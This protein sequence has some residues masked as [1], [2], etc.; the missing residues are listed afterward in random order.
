VKKAYICGMKRSVI[1]KSVER[2]RG[3]VRQALSPTFLSIVLCAAVLWYIAKLG[4][5][6]TTELDM[7][8]RIDGQKY[9]LSVV[10]YGRGSAILAQQLSLKSRLNL[11]LDELSPRPSRETLGALTI[12]PAS[13]TKAINT[14]LTDEDIKIMEVT[15]APEFIPPGAD[16]EEHSEKEKGEKQSKKDKDSSDEGETPR[17]KRKRERLERRQAKEAAR[18]AE[19]EKEAKEEAA[20]RAAK[21]KKAAAAR[22]SK[23][24]ETEAEIDKKLRAR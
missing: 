23:R 12:S 22:A 19:A 14:K 17:E 1:N 3:I 5:E 6:Y 20:A 11:T 21:E 13:L 4:R 8:V 18:A 15:E 9:R 16:E 2:I 7:S 24:K 10:V